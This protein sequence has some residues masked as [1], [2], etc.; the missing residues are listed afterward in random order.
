MKIR[1]IVSRWRR[2]KPAENSLRC[3]MRATASVFRVH[4]AELTGPRIKAEVV[5]PRQIGMAIGVRVARAS[6]LATARAFGRKDHTT[7]LRAIKKYGDIVE[8]AIVEH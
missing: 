5:I 8:N 4:D 7:V 2:R 1:F 3:L 6:M